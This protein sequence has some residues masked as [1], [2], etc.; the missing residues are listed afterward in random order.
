MPTLD[1]EPWWRQNPIVTEKS[2]TDLCGGC[3]H[4]RWR[5]SGIPCSAYVSGT[6]EV[7]KCACDGGYDYHVASFVGFWDEMG[8][9]FPELLYEKEPKDEYGNI[10]WW[11]PTD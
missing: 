5:H 8:K 1:A 2:P 11:I 4:V 9:R 6:G 3:G 10:M 7:T